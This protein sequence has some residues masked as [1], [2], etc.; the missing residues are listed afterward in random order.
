MP[1]SGQCVPNALTK[2]SKEVWLT[3]KSQ[4]FKFTQNTNEYKNPQQMKESAGVTLAPKTSDI[5]A[6]QNEFAK[7]KNNKFRAEFKKLKDIAGLNTHEG[8]KILYMHNFNG[9]I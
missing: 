6:M 3:Q 7:L 8:K 5:K 2:Q 4:S 1:K 9:Y